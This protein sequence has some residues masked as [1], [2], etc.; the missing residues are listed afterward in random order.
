LRFVAQVSLR[1]K[2]LN[3]SKPFPG[4]P[5]GGD[6]PVLYLTLTWVDV[7]Q[8]YKLCNWVDDVD[9][10]LNIPIKVVYFVDDLIGPVVFVHYFH[11]A[12]RDPDWQIEVYVDKDMNVEFAT[13]RL[14]D[15]LS[16][17]ERDIAGILKS[18][19]FI[20]PPTKPPAAP[21]TQP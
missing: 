2:M 10:N 16:L 4:W 11:Q 9:N 12:Q 1:G 7:R 15:V 21:P 6:R 20:F 19:D 8:R 18:S 13:G 5:S 3:T 17:R 14:V